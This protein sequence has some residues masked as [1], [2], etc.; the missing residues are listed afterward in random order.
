M[1]CLECEKNLEQ[2]EGKREREF[3]NTT[4]RSNFWQKV[5]RDIASFRKNQKAAKPPAKK[6]EDKKVS[7]DNENTS[8]KKLSIMEQIEENRKQFLNPKNK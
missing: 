6:T 8:T 4:C 7:A 5:K 3:C 2:T 1:R